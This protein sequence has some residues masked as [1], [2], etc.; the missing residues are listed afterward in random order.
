MRTGPNVQLVDFPY[1][2]K[3]IPQGTH[4]IIKNLDP[5]DL[6]FPTIIEPVNENDPGVRK[7][8]LLQTSPRSRRKRLPSPIDLDAQKYSTDL[9]RFNE[10]ALPLAYL[11]E[12]TFRSHYANRLKRDNEAALREGG[13]DFRAE[14]IPTRMLV[15]ADGDILANDVGTPRTLLPAS[16]STAS[17][18]F[19]MPT[20]P[21]CSTRSSTCSIRRA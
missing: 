7:T 15:V 3:A 20:R 16:A 12:G 2:I 1:N 13:L 10:N 9:D 4:P 19:S 14:S 6:K 21:S 18:S 5:I 17:R 11:L 8:V